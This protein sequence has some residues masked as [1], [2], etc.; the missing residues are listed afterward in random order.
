MW[1]ASSADWSVS[2]VSISALSNVFLDL[3]VLIRNY[4]SHGSGR[5][6]FTF[7]VCATRQFIPIPLPSAFFVF[8]WTMLFV[9]FFSF[10]PPP[11]GFGRENTDCWPQE[12][13][14]RE[15]C[16][17]C[18]KSLGSVWTSQRKKHWSIFKIVHPILER[19]I[20]FQQ[21]FQFLDLLMAVLYIRKSAKPYRLHP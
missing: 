16:S 5:S 11:Y 14:D 8:N 4:F 18:K 13:H 19:K 15:P 3:S 6:S 10:F 9:A 21:K 2:W 20:Y 1:F 12:V 7:S 17:S